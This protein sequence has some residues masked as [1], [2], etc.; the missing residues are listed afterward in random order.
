LVCFLLA[1][2]GGAVHHAA[3]PKPHVRHLATV[4]PSKLVVTVLD[5]NRNVRV[6][7]AT[8]RLWHRAARTN[9]H[10]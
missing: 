1:G 10:V 6:R 4:R 3:A 8:V 2:C 7:G 9:V 5:G